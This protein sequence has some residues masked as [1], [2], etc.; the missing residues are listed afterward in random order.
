[1]KIAAV[2]YISFFE[3]HL[4]QKVF[5]VN[6]DCTWKDAMEIAIK[7]G[8]IP[9]MEWGGDFKKWLLGMPDD[10]EETRIEM[11]NGEMDLT[12]TFFEK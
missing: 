8:I 6:S 5:E 2:A 12:V 11:T 3:N 10:L 1:M 9:D 7:N 4:Y